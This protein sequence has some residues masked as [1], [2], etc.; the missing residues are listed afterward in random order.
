[1]LK[2]RISSAVGLSCRHS[3]HHIAVSTRHLTFLR[4]LKRSKLGLSSTGKNFSFVQS[5]FWQSLKND[6]LVC[7]LT[8]FSQIWGS[9]FVW[10]LKILSWVLFKSWQLI[11]TFSRI[12][13]V[14][15]RFPWTT[16][17][18][19][20]CSNLITLVTSLHKEHWL[21][22][23]ACSSSIWAKRYKTRSVSSTIFVEGLNGQIMWKNIGSRGFGG[24]QA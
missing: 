17:K 6:G 16:T 8:Q 5:R 20:I 3:W 15:K 21:F 10:D 23:A 22:V 9:K 19:L 13:S 11:K 12:S 2:P 4:F 7:S 1:M 18:P 14:L 24:C